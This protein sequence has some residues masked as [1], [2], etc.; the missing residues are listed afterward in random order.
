VEK[1]ISLACCE[2]QTAVIP[3]DSAW[4]SCCAFGGVSESFSISTTCPEEAPVY[5]WECRLT[6]ARIERRGSEGA[7][8]EVPRGFSDLATMKGER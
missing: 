7:D 2:T 1:C 8:A 4:D 6:R 5:L 3:L